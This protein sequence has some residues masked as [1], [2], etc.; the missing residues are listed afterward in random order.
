MISFAEAVAFLRT[1]AVAD[2]SGGLHWPVINNLFLLACAF[3]SFRAIQ[4]TDKNDDTQ[5]L[6]F[7]SVFV[8]FDLACSL[9]NWIFVWFIP[10]YNWLK[11][12]FILFLGWLGGA[13]LLFKY[14]EPHMLNVELVNAKYATRDPER[15]PIARKA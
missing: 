15:Q 9:I 10:V 6:T 2:C 14:I 5:W 13:Q 12:L 4:S 3:K 1:V 11:M 8:L 7:W